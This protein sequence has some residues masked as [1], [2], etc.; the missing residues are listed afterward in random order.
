MKALFISRNEGL[1]QQIA[2]FGAM[3][4]PPLAIVSVDSLHEASKVI[5][6]DA[7]RL[8]A[9]DVASAGAGGIAALEKLGAQHPRSALMLVT[10]N[11]SPELLLQ[12]MRAGV[13]EVLT[14]PL[15]QEAFD[16]AVKRVM[17]KVEASDRNGKVISFISCKGGSGATFLST[18]F[19]HALAMQAD[20]KVLLIDLDRQFGDAALYVSEKKPAMTLSDV[21]AQIN[22]IDA[23]FLESSLVSVAPNLGILAASDDPTHSVDINPGHIDTIL[24][25]ARTCYDYV[26]LDVGRQIDAVSISA[27]DHSDL[28]YSVLQMTMPYI[29]DAGRL[30]EVF[31]SLGY[32][33]DKA[34]LILNRYEKSSALRL[35]DVEKA[36]GN[37]EIHTMPNNYKVVTE[38]INQ[39]VPVLQLAR[40]SPMSKSLIGLVD[41]LAETAPD[42]DGSFF[43]RLFN[44]RVQ[45][46]VAHG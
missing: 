41:E 2:S 6:S 33:R 29:R 3:H 21:C 42:K 15:E 37:R 45:A 35:S 30:L 24:R 43:M 36:L 20:K 22:R 25:L 26:V 32:G 34:Q 31:N 10:A 13:R 38:S 40:N 14:L 27:L 16:D 46:S 17:H 19:A 7:P 11:Q 39:G 44:N 5:G 18:N 1:R 23:A 4:T 28:I 9:F 8:V 12:A